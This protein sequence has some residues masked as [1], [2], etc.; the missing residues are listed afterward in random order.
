MNPSSCRDGDR[1]EE[2]RKPCELRL[3]GDEPQGGP[4]ATRQREGSVGERVRK[5][6]APEKAHRLWSASKRKTA[7]KKRK[8]YAF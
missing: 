7:E 8:G 1:E 2:E 3:H 5:P 4:A 6:E